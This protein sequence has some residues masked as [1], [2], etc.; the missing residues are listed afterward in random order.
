MMMQEQSL[1]NLNPTAQCASVA[2]ATGQA[3]AACCGVGRV[4]TISALPRL[5][6]T[7]HYSRSHLWHIVNVA[8]PHYEQYLM[9][10]SMLILTSCVSNFTCTGGVSGCARHHLC[11]QA[12]N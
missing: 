1:R 6:P 5:A 12:R 3:V 7:M 2:V 8:R 11:W 9:H 10:R 4:L